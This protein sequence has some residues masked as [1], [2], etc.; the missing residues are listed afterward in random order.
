[1]SDPIPMPSPELFGKSA[2]PVNEELIAGAIANLIAATRAEGRSL[3][4]LTAQVLADDQLL[5]LEQRLRLSDVVAS[6]W[7]QLPEFTELNPW[8]ANICDGETGGE[9]LDYTQPLSRR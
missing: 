5:N 4:D 6:A 3:E 7:Q 8:L 2:V 1:M 9:P